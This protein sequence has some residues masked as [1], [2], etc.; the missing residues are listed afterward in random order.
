MNPKRSSATHS[1]DD[2]LSGKQ[3]CASSPPRNFSEERT[4]S[5]ENLYGGNMNGSNRI[6]LLKGEQR[7]MLFRWSRLRQGCR[8]YSRLY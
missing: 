6:R 3:W 7:I 4:N 5:Q 8:F 2:S 1:W